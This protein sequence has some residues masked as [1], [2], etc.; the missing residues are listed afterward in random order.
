MFRRVITPSAKKSL[1]RLSRDAEQELLKATEMLITNPHT[2][3]KLHGSLS[4]LFSFHFKFQNVQYRVAY[5]IEAMQKL[6]IIHLVGPRENFYDRL[7][8]LF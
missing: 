7:R 2:G 6:V 1:K 3:E 4:F 8:R 5:T